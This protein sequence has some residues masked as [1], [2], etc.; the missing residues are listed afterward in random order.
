MEI[1][2]MTLVPIAVAWLVDDG[3]GADFPKRVWPGERR[4]EEE[5]VAGGCTEAADDVAAA[6][7]TDSSDT[8]CCKMC[9][10]IFNW[11]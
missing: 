7:V 3:W 4:T 8:E 6:L 10:G 9:V 11:I 2:R 5:E 1:T